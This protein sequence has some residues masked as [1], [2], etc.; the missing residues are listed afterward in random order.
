[1]TEDLDEQKQ[2]T[3]ED[4]KV[5]KVESLLAMTRSDGFYQMVELMIRKAKE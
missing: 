3:I 2:V 4:F 1:M 5:F